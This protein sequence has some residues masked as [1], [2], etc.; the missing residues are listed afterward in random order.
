M[1]KNGAL[2]A[3]GIVFIVMALLHVVH[4]LFGIQVTVAGFVLPQWFS[5]IGCAFFLILGLWMFLAM[6]SKEQP[7]A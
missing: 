1:R 7:F 6:N 3:A 5:M 4:M 2:S